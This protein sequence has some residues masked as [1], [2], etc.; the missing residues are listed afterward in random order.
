MA[1]L[2]LNK[3]LLAKVLRVSRPTIYEWFSGK[4]P[5]PGNEER[6]QRLLDILTQASVSAE[7]PIN[8]RFVRRP[9]A[10]GVPPLVDLLSEERIDAPRVIAAIDQARTLAE[11]GSRRQRDREERLRALGFE[12]SSQ[13]QRRETLARNVALLEW[14]AGADELEALSLERL[15]DRLSTEE[16]K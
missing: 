12:E 11:E 8:A 6:L 13:E 7:S 14:P 1:A 4:Q 2:G 9:L 3:S 5:K 10:H 16:R 15:T